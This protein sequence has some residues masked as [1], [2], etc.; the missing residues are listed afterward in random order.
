MDIRTLSGIC[1]LTGFIFARTFPIL[2]FRFG[3]YGRRDLLLGF[4][5][6]QEVEYET[7]SYRR[8]VSRLGC[9]ACVVRRAG[10]RRGARRVEGAAQDAP[11]ANRAARSP[12]EADGGR[13][14]EGGGEPTKGRG[15]PAIF[16]VLGRCRGAIPRFP[17]AATSSST[18]ST[19]STKISATPSSCTTPGATRARSRWMARWMLRKNSP[20]TPGKRASDSTVSRRRSWAS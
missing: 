3:S 12:R 7:K 4:F 18:R 11:Q 15:D 6:F 14:E 16:Q 1:Y 9:S 13:A 19:I 17:S 2:R 20:C 5:N 10:D 8:R